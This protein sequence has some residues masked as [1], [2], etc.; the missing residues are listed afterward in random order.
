MS[1]ELED[2]S[3]LKIFFQKQNSIVFCSNVTRLSISRWK[4]CASLRQPHW[5]FQIRWDAAIKNKKKLKKSWDYWIRLL[6]CKCP[7]RWWMPPLKFEEQSWQKDFFFFKNR[8]FSKNRS[9]QK[10]VGK[11][12]NVYTYIHKHIPIKTYIYKRWMTPSNFGKQKLEKGKVLI[13]N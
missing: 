9:W 7:R 3:S 5:E 12:K 11:I 13:M 6:H 1:P 8:S 2:L 10:E 4:K